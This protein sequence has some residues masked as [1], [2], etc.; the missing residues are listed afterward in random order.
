MILHNDTAAGSRLRGEST[1]DHSFCRVQKKYPA[2]YDTKTDFT[3]DSID[4][5][6][7][8]ECGNGC[9][10]C[11]EEKGDD[12]SPFVYQKCWIERLQS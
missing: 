11:G 9:Q 7:R 10:G 4:P 12:S 8:D 3:V 1:K 5:E 6:R 2:V